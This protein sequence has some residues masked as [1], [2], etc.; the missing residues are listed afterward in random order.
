M[1]FLEGNTNFFVIKIMQFNIILTANS[2]I[3]SIRLE[4]LKPPG[5]CGK[6]HNLNMRQ[7]VS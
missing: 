5:E 4:R 7:I 1:S 3:I 6:D 2:L